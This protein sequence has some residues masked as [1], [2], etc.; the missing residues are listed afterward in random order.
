MT[1]EQFIMD[2]Q[3]DTIANLRFMLF[4]H[5][6]QNRFSFS[7][8]RGILKGKE[9]KILEMLNW[10][11]ACFVT[12]PIGDVAATAVSAE[13][14]QITIYIATNRGRPRDRDRENGETF[15][16]L[17]RETIGQ[18]DRKAIVIQLMKVVSP[19][20]Y[21]RLVRK[22]NLITRIDKTESP[23]LVQ[24]RFNKIVDRWVEGGNIEDDVGFLSLSEKFTP[25]NMDRNQRLKHTFG[26]IVSTAT[27]TTMDASIE[28]GHHADAKTCQLRVIS[29][30]TEAFAL[31]NSK[32]FKI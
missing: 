12:E 3:R 13:Q 22:V 4:E 5:Q 21:H 30:T 10:I 28:G 25:R 24:D 8:H 1:Q 14:G 29:F 9:S 19:I 15:K 16:Q 17:L 31:L 7:S 6:R 26:R 27:S 2:R 11:A 20:I 18:S 32:F 23:D